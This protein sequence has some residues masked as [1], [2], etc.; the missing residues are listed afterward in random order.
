[1]DSM[2]SAAGATGMMVGMDQMRSA[3]PMSSMQQQTMMHYNG[4][5]AV[6]LINNHNGGMG[7]R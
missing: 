2:D 6:I 4:R 3:T 1:M 5:L 7:C